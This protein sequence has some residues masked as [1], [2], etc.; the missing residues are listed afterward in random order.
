MRWTYILTSS[1]F[2]LRRTP[3]LSQKILFI[4]F[5]IDTNRWSQCQHGVVGVIFS[6]E[7][8]RWM[9]GRLWKYCDIFM[10]NDGFCSDL[11]FGWSNWLYGFVGRS[12]DLTSFNTE[13]CRT[14]L[15]MLDTKFNFVF[16]MISLK[17][18]TKYTKDGVRIS[19]FFISVTYFN[20]D[21][22]FFIEFES[23]MTRSSR[24]Y[25][26]R[27]TVGED[28]NYIAVSV[29]VIRPESVKLPVRFGLFWSALSKF[30]IFVYLN[31]RKIV[32]GTI[33]LVHFFCATLING[34][35]KDT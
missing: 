19:F 34:L 13:N 7:N 22:L 31:S 15:A 21:T 2:I 11:W 9:F 33:W 24:L 32:V 14:F 1:L 20:A 10:Y 30:E 17:M 28:K 8:F 6:C 3:H 29:N 4:P 16:I 5:A 25:T 26:K 18:S 12:R 23:K 27:P 35:I